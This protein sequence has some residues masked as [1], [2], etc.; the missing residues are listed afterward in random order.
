MADGTDPVAGETSTCQFELDGER[1]CTNRALP[2]Q[3]LCVCHSPNRSV[4]Q[5]EGFVVE[6]NRMLSA[7]NYSFRGF[8]FPPGF[9]GFGSREFDGPALF[10]RARFLGNAYFPRATFHDVAGFQE[11]VFEGDADFTN[12]RFQWN[13]FFSDV[14]F[15]KAANFRGMDC[16]RDLVFAPL[17]VKGDANL[18]GGSCRELADLSGATFEGQVDLSG[19]HFGRALHIRHVVFRSEVDMAMCQPPL[20]GTFEHVEVPRGEGE[21]SYHFGMLLLERM[22]DRARAGDLF[23]KSR[24]HRSHRKQQERQDRTK[25]LLSS[26]PLL[27]R[28]SSPLACCWALLLSLPEL[29]FFRWFLGYG[30]RPWRVALNGLLIILV[31]GV[32]FASVPSQLVHA[33][34]SSRVMSLG[35]GIYFSVVTFV[36]LGFGDW[37]P[38]AGSFVA[39]IAMAE[40]LIGAFLLAAFLVSL[41]RRYGRG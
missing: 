1:I 18:R 11:A 7:R 29:L 38:R 10:I 27:K 13:A 17:V 21:T 25:A 28:A 34:C 31:S 36:T 15:R 30:E 16:G 6:V 23:L 4:K 8:V 37:H 33:D 3:T 39:Y 24:A 12:V 32:V 19:F 2:G 9:V 5:D 22:G 26:F 20:S 35:E 14:E 41:M 40:A